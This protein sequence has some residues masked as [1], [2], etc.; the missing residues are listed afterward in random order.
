MVDF[1]LQEQPAPVDS[2]APHM[3]ITISTAAAMVNTQPSQSLSLAAQ[4][5]KSLVSNN[6]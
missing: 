5:L 6:V 1:L 2:M 3:G 4:P